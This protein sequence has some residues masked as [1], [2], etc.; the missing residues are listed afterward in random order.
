MGRAKRAPAGSRGRA[1][2]GG[3]A[4]LPENFYKLCAVTLLDINTELRE[5]YIKALVVIF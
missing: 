2:S 3:G 1:P 5:N 4:E